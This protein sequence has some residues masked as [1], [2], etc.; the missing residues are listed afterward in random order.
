MVL[1]FISPFSTRAAGSE[2]R[3]YYRLTVS[4]SACAP[5]KLIASPAWCES[6][7]RTSAPGMV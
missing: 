6:P 1:G 4:A 3:R 2:R 5:P 7:A